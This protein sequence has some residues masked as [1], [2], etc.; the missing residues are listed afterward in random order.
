MNDLASIIKQLLQDDVERNNLGK[1]ARDWIIENR[2]WTQVV[3]NV[4]EFYQRNT[5]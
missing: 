4:P 2:T 5:D 3:K 1:N